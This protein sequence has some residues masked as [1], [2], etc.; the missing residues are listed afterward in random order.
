M[1]WR[2]YY[3]S[4]KFNK[5]IYDKNLHKYYFYNILTNNV[6]WNKPLFYGKLLNKYD[7]GKVIVKLYYKYN[8]LM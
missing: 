1:I 5:K 8:I 7:A 2:R 6:S 4:H 3:R